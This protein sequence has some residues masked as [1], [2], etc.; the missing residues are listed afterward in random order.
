[1]CARWLNWY[2]VLTS[3]LV[4]REPNSKITMLMALLH[5]SLLDR[6]Q[7]RN[8]VASGQ[9]CDCNKSWLL[10][11]NTDPALPAQFEILELR[12]T[13][14]DNVILRHSIQDYESKIRETH[15]HPEKEKTRQSTLI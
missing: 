1:M 13:P 8:A 9:G 5:E 6:G 7:Y 4:M 11:R 14:R 10:M 2:L 12:S 3:H 15:E